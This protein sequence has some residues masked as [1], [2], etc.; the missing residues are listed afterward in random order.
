M[1]RFTEP[2]FLCRKPSNRYM[3]ALACWLVLLLTIPAPQSTPK[4]E[5]IDAQTLAR[6]VVANEL[7][8][9]QEDHTR[10]MYVV[11]NEEPGKKEIQAV[12]DTGNW[13][14][15]RTLSRNN[16]PLSEDQQRREDKRIEELVHD[17]GQQH[18]ES[19]K[20]QQDMHRAL[21]MLRMLPEAFLFQS[22]GKEGPYVRLSFQP[23]PSFHPTTRAARVSRAIS[24][25]MLVDRAQKRLVELDGAIT[26]DVKFG[27]GILGIIKK[28]G[29]F[30]VKQTEVGPGHWALTLIDIQI[31]GKVLLFH[32]IGEQQRQ[33]FSNF[34]RLP[35]N[36]ALAQ[37]AEMLKEHARSASLNPLKTP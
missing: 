14:L 2:R 8:A 21:E 11:H 23:N 17:S 28:G 30:A 31:R 5:E 25:T 26:C 34:R 29:S 32:T 36:V 18:D 12:I 15:Y 7:H 6:G 10:W 13:L 4:G 33:T 19:R 9:R 27:A 3:P 37:A 35:Q 16:Q 1:W 24:G 20:Y 22:V